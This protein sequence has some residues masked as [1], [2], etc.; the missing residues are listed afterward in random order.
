MD[1]VIY[2]DYMVNRIFFIIIIYLSLATEESSNL[3]QKRQ[4]SGR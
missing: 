1:R 2:R 3:R 4:R